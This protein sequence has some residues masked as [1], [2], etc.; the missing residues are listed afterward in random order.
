MKTK[1]LR[2]FFILFIGLY[3]CIGIIFRSGF[4]LFPFFSFK[5]FS[6]KPQVFE[7]YD[8]LTNKTKKK[9]YFLLLDNDSL[10]QIETSYIRGILS[11]MRVAD[12][13]ERQSMTTKL[14]LFLPKNGGY[15]LVRLNGNLIDFAKDR[16]YQME[17]LYEF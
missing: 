4:E 17:L 1:A 8:I 15:K 12:P 10:N 9:D 13:V 16:L 6:R 11:N 7:H 14:K 2:L 5:L 3:F